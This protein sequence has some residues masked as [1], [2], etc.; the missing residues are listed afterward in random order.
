MG[1]ALLVNFLKIISVIQ[2]GAK[3]GTGVPVNEQSTF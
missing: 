1:L 2:V 3:F